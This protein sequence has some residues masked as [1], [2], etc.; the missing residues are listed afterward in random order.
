MIILDGC[1]IEPL[2]K[3]K[4][5]FIDEIIERGFSSLNCKAVFP[6]ATYTGHSAI[7]TGSYPNKNGMVANQFFDRND[8][9]SKHFDNFDPNLYINMNT[10]FEY[11]KN[12][13]P[14]S[15]C[16]PVYRGAK[17]IILPKEI[18]EFPVEKRNEII[19][20]N[21]IKLIK[22][23][24]SDFFMINF[25]AVDSIGE[26]YGPNSNKYKET[27][28]KVDGYL[29][30]LYNESLKLKETGLIITADH[31][32]TEIKSYFNLQHYIKE[33]GFNEVICLPSHRICHIY[34]LGV[35]IN[36]LLPYIEECKKVG[37][38]LTEKDF[39][40]LN[41]NHERSG[42]LL[43][44][45]NNHIEFEVKNLN[46]SHG[47]LSTEEMTVPLLLY[48]FNEFEFELNNCQIIDILPT[49]LDIYNV[50]SVNNLDGKS[51]V[52]E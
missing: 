11:L 21:S 26:L 31:G 38:I 20:Q 47:G 37:K 12:L 22:N 42:D 19:Y 32:L 36:E 27:L 25:S 35:S 8:N 49:I 28:E 1:P 10:I 44:I 13:N 33:L 16:E 30:D 23:N 3:A 51:L 2:R 6:T 15:I 50:K 9:L 40:K 5:T 4:T 46:G 52:I 7:I 41:I 45:A 48:G 29:N 24:N 43:A 34:L 17:K 39:Y 18:N 14:I